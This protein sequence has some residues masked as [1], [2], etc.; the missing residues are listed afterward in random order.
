MRHKTQGSSSRRTRA[1]GYAALEKTLFRQL[2]EIL[3]KT[4]KHKKIRLGLS[5]GT[6]NPIHLWH[7]QVAQCA[8]DQ[9]KLWKVLFIPNG[10]PVHK[11]GV[12]NKELRFRMVQA[13][14]DGNSHFFASRIETDREGKSY[15]VD[16]LRELK[17]RFGDRVELCLIVGLDNIEPDS[18]RPILKWM[19]PDEIFKLCTLLIAP[20]NSKVCTRERISTLLPAGVN[21]EI[22]DCPDTDMSSTLIRNWYKAGRKHSADYLVPNKVRRLI[23]RHRLY[24]D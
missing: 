9:L 16:T 21:F 8:W 20:R 19:E 11:T 6:F 2:A 22:I 13:A 12:V 7:L 3:A 14:C 4:P 17:K 23:A 10:D 15:T 18:E 1:V 5:M 24:R